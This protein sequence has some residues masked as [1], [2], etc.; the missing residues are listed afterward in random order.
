MDPEQRS[1]STGISG[2]ILSEIPGMPAKPLMIM[3]SL[4]EF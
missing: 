2:A 1:G 4:K 3:L